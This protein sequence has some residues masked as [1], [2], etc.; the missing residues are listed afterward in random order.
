MRLEKEE[1]LIVTQRSKRES[2]D[3]NLMT[4]WIFSMGRKKIESN[5]FMKI[6][7]DFHQFGKPHSRNLDVIFL[8]DLTSD[9]Q[10]TKIYQTR[11]KQ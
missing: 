8:F 1:K 9:K 2:K 5:F 10:W 3:I 6:K 7:K 11:K 4:I